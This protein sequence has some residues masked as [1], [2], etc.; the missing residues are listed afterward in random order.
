MI[1]TLAYIKNLHK[2]EKN[3]FLFTEQFRQQIYLLFS[4]SKNAQL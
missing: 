3:E 4:G 2:L 1:L